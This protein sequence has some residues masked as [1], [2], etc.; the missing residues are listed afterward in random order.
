M[1]YQI[2]QVAERV[3]LSLRTLRHYH[4]VGL[5]VPSTRTP[6]GFRLYSDDDL[7]RLLLIKRM[8]PLGFTLGEMRDLLEIRD[9]LGAPG[10]GAEERAQLLERLSSFATTAREQCDRLRRQLEYAEDFAATLEQRV[11]QFSQSASPSAAPSGLQRDEATRS[12]EHSD[13]SP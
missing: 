3:G 8:K 13:S 2:G 11:R 12:P 4:D 10:L 1:A 7:D 5:V 9:R 6:G